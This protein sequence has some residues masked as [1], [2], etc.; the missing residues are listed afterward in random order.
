[1]I[2]T[3]RAVRDNDIVLFYNDKGVI[4]DSGEATHF[5]VIT[6]LGKILHESKLNKPMLISRTTRVHTTNG[7]DLFVLDV[8]NIKLKLKRRPFWE[9]E[10]KNE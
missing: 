5:K 4:E 8:N 2:H 6:R 10:A 3:N 9:T 7:K 1:M